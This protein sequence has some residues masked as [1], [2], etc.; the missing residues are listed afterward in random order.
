MDLYEVTSPDGV[1][2][3]IK[4]DSFEEA[5]LIVSKGDADLS[6][7]VTILEENDTEFCTD[8]G[9]PKKSDRG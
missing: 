7:V 8:C 4:A 3:F 6:S 2:E 9:L 5:A 1:V